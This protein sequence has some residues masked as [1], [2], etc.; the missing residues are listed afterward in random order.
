[1]LGGDLGPGS[2]TKHDDPRERWGAEATARRQRLIEELGFLTRRSGRTIAQAA[3]EFVLSF[4]AVSTAIPGTVSIAHLEENAAAA[5]GRLSP[6]E[7]SRLRDLLD[8][9]FESLNLG[10]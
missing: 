8:G 4:E 1:M 9:K 6:G 3:L 2:A 7:M 10:W 5:G